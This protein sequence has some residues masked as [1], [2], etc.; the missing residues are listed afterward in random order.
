VAA[1]H[2]T[3]PGAV[4]LAWVLANPA[5]TAAIVGARRRGQ[6]ADVVAAAG[7]TLSAAD[8]AAIAAG[9]AAVA[10]PA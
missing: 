8:R 4:A 9:L 6:L 2:G 10:A 5:V 3:T 7:L 1:G